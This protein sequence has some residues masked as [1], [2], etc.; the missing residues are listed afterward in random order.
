MVLEHLAAQSE[1]GPRAGM[2]LLPLGP[3][4][5]VSKV[6]VL[7]TQQPLGRWTPR[8]VAK[9]PVRQALTPQR[10][11]LLLRSS[12]KLARKAKPPRALRK[13]LTPRA[14]KASR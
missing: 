13:A 9:R 2:M 4:L 1:P 8:R 5:V 3:L 11:S 12:V 7:V 14:K 10:Y 6:Q